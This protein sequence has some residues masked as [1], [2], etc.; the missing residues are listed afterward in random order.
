MRKEGLEEA[1]KKKKSGGKRSRIYGARGQGVRSR[2]AGGNARGPVTQAGRYVGVKRIISVSDL[3]RLVSG[4]DR[5]SE[6]RERRR[7]RRR[8]RRYIHR[9]A[10]RIIKKT[11]AETA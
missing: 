1:R 8:R 3:R 9:G 5:I 6:G 11:K 4:P 2:A 10:S 7:R